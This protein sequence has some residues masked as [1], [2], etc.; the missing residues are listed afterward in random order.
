LDHFIELIVERDGIDIGDR[1]VSREE[2][3]ASPERVDT[4]RRWEA[5]NDLLY[6]RGPGAGT[7]S[8]AR[9]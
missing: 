5:K 3:E 8:C 6:S 4:L 1:T 9:G 2:L 7:D